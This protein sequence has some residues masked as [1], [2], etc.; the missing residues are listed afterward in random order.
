MSTMIQSIIASTIQLVV[1][2]VYIVITVASPR[3]ATDGSVVA[4]YMLSTSINFYAFWRGLH[5][6]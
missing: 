2:A 5:D 1:T 4:L 3:T 6:R